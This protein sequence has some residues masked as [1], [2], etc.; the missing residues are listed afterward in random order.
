MED[1]GLV[2]SASWSARTSSS[3]TSQSDMRGR[4]SLGSRISINLDDM[5]R[6]FR[7]ISDL[8]EGSLWWLSILFSCW[9]ECGFNVFFFLFPLLRR[10]S[11]GGSGNFVRE[12]V[13]GGKSKP[14]RVGEVGS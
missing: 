13:G 3:R 2:T 9:L 4:V 14:N 11:R 8:V 1:R 5:S 12:I 7:L 6:I 10:R